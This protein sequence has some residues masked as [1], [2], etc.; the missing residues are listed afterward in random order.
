M[1]TS[2]IIVSPC[3]RKSLI[4]SRQ[5][6]GSIQREPVP[7]A[8]FW[9]SCARNR[10][11]VASAFARN[12]TLS[13]QSTVNCLMS[14]ETQRRTVLLRTNLYKQPSNVPPASFLVEQHA[15]RDNAKRS[16]SALGRPKFGRSRTFFA[17]HAD[18]LVLQLFL[19]LLVGGLPL[20]P[21]SLNSSYR[22]HWSAP[23]TRSNPPP[24]QLLYRFRCLSW[25]SH[26]SRFDTCTT[27]RKPFSERRIPKNKAIFVLFLLR[28]IASPKRA[29]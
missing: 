16:D 1:R 24:S 19:L 3:Q 12:Q 10:V 21:F 27:N 22:C 29:I 2:T 6:V 8:H 17:V 9:K 7:C 28:N 25:R 20:A 14:G 13:G 11:P 5:K 15:Q 26:S 4:W 18:I 23:R